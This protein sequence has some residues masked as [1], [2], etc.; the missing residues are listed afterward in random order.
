MG[1]LG[2]PEI[3]K[4][5]SQIK[6]ITIV[7]NRKDGGQRG[8]QEH[9]Q[10]EFQ[11]HYWERETPRDEE[12]KDFF[13]RS[14]MNKL[15]RMPYTPP[16]RPLNEQR[17]PFL[18]PAQTMTMWKFHKLYYLLKYNFNRSKNNSLINN[19]NTW[20]LNQKESIFV[21]NILL[22]ICLHKT[23]SFL[24]SPLKSRRPNKRYLYYRARSRKLE[25]D[26]WYMKRFSAVESKN[27]Y[28]DSITLGEDVFGVSNFYCFNL[29]VS[30]NRWLLSNQNL[31]SVFKFKVFELIA[32]YHQY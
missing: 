18:W 2:S 32:N 19:K 29:N 6:F 31:L 7:L 16:I 10:M 20:N 23:I 25:Q 28:K 11:C 22:C 21:K 3:R 26:T 13:F 15:Y 12:K 9:F 4:F 30:K 8:P 17:A 1:A 27:K 24:Y 5:L 14:W